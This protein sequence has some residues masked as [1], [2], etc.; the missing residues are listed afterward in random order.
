[1]H[2]SIE[3]HSHDN[4]FGHN[5]HNASEL[6]TRV[7]SR[8]IARPFINSTNMNNKSAYHDPFDSIIA[9]MMPV[10]WFRHFVEHL[11]GVVRATLFSPSTF[12]FI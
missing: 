1:M 3:K 10:I 2:D 6:Q 4:G 11:A 9:R 12:L 5:H 8:L 7:S